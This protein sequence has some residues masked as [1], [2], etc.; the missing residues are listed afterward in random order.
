MRRFR[1][2]VNGTTYEVEVEEVGGTAP[3]ASPVQPA[4]AK[5]APSAPAPAAN[6]AKRAAAPKPAAPRGGSS[7]TAPMPGTIIDIKVKEGDKVEPRTVVAMLEAMKM[8]NEIFAGRS[9]V[10]THIAVEKGAS[11]NTGDLLVSI[12]PA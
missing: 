3:Q 6:P 7:V 12:D 9:G 2:L 5:P 8:E 4:T 1:V 10:V 11:V